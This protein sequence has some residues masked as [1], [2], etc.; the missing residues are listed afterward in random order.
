MLLLKRFPDNTEKYVKINSYSYII[1]NCSLPPF[2]TTQCHD[3]TCRVVFCR[4]TE[5]FSSVKH[6]TISINQQFPGG[7]LFLL[8]SDQEFKKFLIRI[9]SKKLE[10]NSPGCPKH[11]ARIVGKNQLE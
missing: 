1:K 9:S 2:K 4:M 8:L 3:N 11:A 7:T 5:V 6:F 10:E